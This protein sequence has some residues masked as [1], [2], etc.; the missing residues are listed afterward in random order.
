ME[1]NQ[2]IKTN[3]FFWGPLE[4]KEPYRLQMFS[5][6]ISNHSGVWQKVK[7]SKMMFSISIQEISIKKLTFVVVVQDDFFFFFWL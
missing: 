5:I 7:Q 4:T 6:S 2:L 1:Y 3:V